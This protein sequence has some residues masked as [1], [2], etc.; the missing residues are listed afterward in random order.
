MN[1]HLNIH[2]N[3][4]NAV[5]SASARRFHSDDGGGSE[6]GIALV[7]TLL[8]LTMVMALSVG[9]VLA[10]SSQTLIGGYYRNFRGSFYAADSGLNIAV[11]QMESSLIGSVPSSWAAPPIASVSSATTSALAAVSSTSL[12]AGNYAN[13]SWKESFQI[14]TGG[15]T[16]LNLLSG[17]T[18]TAYNGAIPIA[19]QYVWGYTVAATGSSQGTE[20]QAVTQRGTITMNI[21][22]QAQTFTQNFAWYGGFVDQYPDG[23]GPLIPGTMTGPMFTNNAWEFMPTTRQYPSPY[24]FTDPVGQHENDVEYWNASISSYTPSTATSFGTGSNYVAPTFEQGLDLGQNKIALPANDMSQKQAVVDGYG[25]GF[26]GGNT[27]GTPWTT[28][29]PTYGLQTLTNISGTNWSTSTTSGIFMNQGTTA[30]VCG[31]RTPPCMRG[32]GFYVEGGADI[33]LTPGSNDTAQVYTITQGST[34]TTIKVDPAA[35]GTDGNLGTTTITQGGVTYPPING[36]PMNLGIGQAQTMVYVDGALTVHGPAQGQAAIQDNS[37]I[38]ITANGNITATADILYKTEPVTV[39]ADTMVTL[40][41]NAQNQVLGLFTANGNFVT[42]TSQTNIEVDAS[43]ATISQAYSGN[44]TGSG[45]G[46]TSLSRINTFNNVGGMIQ[47]CI[48]SAPITTENTWYDRRFSNVP[49]FA[50][51]FFPSTTITLGG[52]QTTNTTSTVQ[53]LQWEV[54]ENGLSSTGVCN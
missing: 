39:P 52:S 28:S 40:P 35:T 4:Q 18:P 37:M 23:T 31:S 8:I 36:V 17:P 47:S 19:Y 45:G 33:K 3:A 27:T 38:T 1:T 43:I 5:S 22:A 21:K 20:Q 16:T 51:P 30:L 32:G 26:D 29:D 13:S 25:T 15:G 2:R 7:M 24:V 54:C 48:Y 9:M 6:R 12:N 10:M 41:A 42:N 46:Q 14:P 49:G 34:T 11:K 44:C 53:R 50:P